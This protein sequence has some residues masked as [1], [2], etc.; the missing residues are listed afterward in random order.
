MH[1]QHET[2][3]AAEWRCGRVRACAA[4]GA[5]Q[6]QCQRVA[7]ETHHHTRLPR[8]QSPE[9]GAHTPTPSAVG[10]HRIVTRTSPLHTT[11]APHWHSPRLRASLAPRD[12]RRRGHE[13]T[14]Q[15]PG[16]SRLPLVSRAQPTETPQRVSHALPAKPRA[17]TPP[18]GQQHGRALIVR[19]P[20][21]VAPEARESHLVP[22]TWRGAVRRAPGGEGRARGGEGSEVG[23]TPC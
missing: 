8:H 1:V 16:H 5:A 11:H 22:A 14:T 9:S 17:H 20:R 6:S 3:Y 21:G 15:R 7:P 4:R 13:H 10:Y 2:F 12:R 18:R 23:R 19:L